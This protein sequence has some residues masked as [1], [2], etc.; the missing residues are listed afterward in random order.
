MSTPSTTYRPVLSL[1]LAAALAACEGVTPTV[2]PPDVGV[3]GIEPAAAKPSCPGHPSCKGDDEPDG[4]AP[5]AILDLAAPSA[6][7]AANE[8]AFRKENK[9]TLE[10]TIPGDEGTFDA[11]LAFDLSGPCA[12]SGDV[13]GVISEA[14][15]RAILAS[16]FVPAG[17]GGFFFAKRTSGPSD[18]NRID[19]VW[20][21][22]PSVQGD[23]VARVPAEASLLAGID[24]PSASIVD[25]GDG[26]R[27]VTVT[28][29]VVRITNRG[30]ADAWPVLE[31]RN[32]DAVVLDANDTP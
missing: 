31:C 14:E 22:D 16:G 10:Y 29:G 11:A 26:T 8:P 12:T 20:D 17:D 19:L 25:H 1:L 13:G 24:P 9:R 18:L 21:P 4:T 2:P 3:A 23:F 5:D 30:A 32:L 7:T 27:T 15:L 28:G 6:L